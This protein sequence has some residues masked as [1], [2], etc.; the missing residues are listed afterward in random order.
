[1]QTPYTI[2]VEEQHLSILGQFQGQAAINP[3]YAYSSNTV[4]AK[5]IKRELSAIIKSAG[6]I[7]DCSSMTY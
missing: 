2:P 7:L 4:C 5:A 3:M 1:M 6:R